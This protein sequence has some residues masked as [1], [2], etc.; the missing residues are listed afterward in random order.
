[1]MQPM[2]HMQ[3]SASL[4]GSSSD[5]RSHSGHKQAHS[6]QLNGLKVI[7]KAGDDGNQDRTGQ[8]GL[9]CG[10]MEERDAEAG[11]AEMMMMRTQS[12]L[13]P[14]EHTVCVAASARPGYHQHSTG[15]R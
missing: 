12:S 3:V 1:M 14:T 5:A 2:Q 10:W 7:I 9:V 6:I 13:L 11:G 4:R 8:E 15:G